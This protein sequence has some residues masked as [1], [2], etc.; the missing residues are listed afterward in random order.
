M[1]KKFFSLFFSLFT[2][3]SI[4]SILNEKKNKFLKLQQIKIKIWMKLKN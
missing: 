2:I 3:I 1:K 4:K